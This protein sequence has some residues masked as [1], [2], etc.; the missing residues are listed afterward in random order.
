MTQGLSVK[1]DDLRRPPTRLAAWVRRH[2]RGVDLAI[3]IV[4]VLLACVPQMIAMILRDSAGEWWGYL[5]LAVV[6]A[7]LMVRRRW[8][9]TVMVVVGVAC[10][11]S[12]LAQPGYGFPQG[13][14]A[15]AI[16]TVASRQSTAR[17]LLGYGIALPATV[18][19]TVP[20]SLN[21]VRPPLPLLDSFSL[22]ALIIGVIVRNRREHNE[23]LTR[24]VN[25]RIENAAVTERTRIAA[26]MHDVVAHALTMVVSL[27]DGARSIREKDPEKA[28]AAV[29]QIASTGREALGEM[30][31]TLGLLRNADA[32]LDANLHHSGDNL[33]SLEELVDDVRAA[34]LGVTLTR[35]GPS[36]PEDTA[37][38]QTIYR[39]VQES[40]TNT[41]R[42]AA[43]ATRAAVAITR[44]GRGVVIT[45]EDDG[46]PVAG[47]IIPGHGLAGIAQRARAYGGTAQSEPRIGG[48]WRTRVELPA[49]GGVDG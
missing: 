28:D 9:F 26:E 11:L 49:P 47:R 18:L 35:T 43:G 27:A 41:L 13:P 1:L 46:A 32:G 29:A 2:Q 40:L 15:F 20:Y 12:P 4:V 33:P 24:F 22:L 19:A 34:G 30:H 14:F 10:A 36:V 42:H 39:I 38:R 37:L 17:A 8:P 45:V 5:I 7:A 31:R 25:Q 21:G 6:A 3:D 48:G 23:W 44:S 16:Y